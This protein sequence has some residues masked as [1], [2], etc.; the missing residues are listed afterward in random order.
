MNNALL[1]P[2]LLILILEVLNGVEILSGLEYA[3]RGCKF[4]NF[5]FFVL[6]LGKESEDT[7]SAQ[8]C[9]GG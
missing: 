7:S 2:L 4:Y 1:L 9:N 6:R 5:F 3:R 8:C